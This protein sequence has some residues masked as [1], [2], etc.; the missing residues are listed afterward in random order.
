[1]TPKQRLGKCR[2]FLA[3][4]QLV[5]PCRV[6]RGCFAHYIRLHPLTVRAIPNAQRLSRW[7][8]NGHNRVN[9]RH[10]KTIVTWYK[11]NKA[12]SACVLASVDWPSCVS[13]VGDPGEYELGELASELSEAVDSTPHHPRQHGLDSIFTM[14]GGG[15]GPL[16]IRAARPGDCTDDKG[17][18]GGRG[19]LKGQGPGRAMV[20]GRDNLSRPGD[21]AANAA[22]NDVDTSTDADTNNGD[23]N[24][25]NDDD[26]DDDEDDEDDEGDG[27][28]GSSGNDDAGGDGDGDGD[29]EGDDDNRQC[30]M[31]PPPSECK[32]AAATER[33]NTE[34]VNTERVNT[35]RT[36]IAE[37]RSAP[38][39]EFWVF[40][41]L[42]MLYMLFDHF[43]DQHDHHPRVRY[44]RMTYAAMMSLLPDILPADHVLTKALR[45]TF[46]LTDEPGS[47][48]ID[49]RNHL[50]SISADSLTKALARVEASTVASEYQIPHD[51]RIARVRSGR[52]G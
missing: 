16:M 22:N 15:A 29:G 33:V 10:G 30:G 48:T 52:V 43:P 17:R 42:M 7:L 20:R 35:A 23:E 36:D 13:L 21:D 24:D 6:C 19:S 31:R 46:A 8:N 27:G 12:F 18:G 14:A 49:W 38:P 40:H 3:L 45:A 1:M 4:V 34:R 39:P 25:D 5:L 11:H 41:L 9:R 26:D 28:A 37:A 2:Q 51:V 50:D 32:P 47:E 44:I